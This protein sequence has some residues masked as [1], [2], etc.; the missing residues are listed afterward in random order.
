MKR[1]KEKWGFLRETTEAAIKAGI[2]RGTGLHRTGLNE[3]LKVIFPDVDDWVHDKA[4]PNMRIR[5]DYRSDTLKLIVE[6]DGLPH[7]TSRDTYL[8]DIEKTKKYESE[9]YKVVRI[10]LY[11]NLT[12]KVINTMFDLKLTQPFFD[13]DISPFNENFQPNCFCLS[14]L[15]R[16]AK[17][18]LSISPEQIQTMMNSIKYLSPDEYKY[19][20]SL[21]L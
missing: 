3:Y 10:P 5:P 15:N 1:V 13:K 7:F 17:D 11:I 8:K 9:G 21:G 19:L 20:Q 12:T 6:F 2:D 16:M 18:F 4:F 14:G